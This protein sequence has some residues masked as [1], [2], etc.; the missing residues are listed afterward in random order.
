MPK[1]ERAELGKKGRQHVLDNYGFKS[2]V[3]QWDKELT[4]TVEKNGSWSTRN[5]KGW[6]LTEIV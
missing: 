6:E 1:E 3:E 2:Y 4:R 5:Y